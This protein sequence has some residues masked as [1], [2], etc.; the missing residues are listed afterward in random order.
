MKVAHLAE[1]PDAI[2]TLASWVYNQWGHWMPA[3]IIPETLAREFEKRT[4]PSC[5]PETFVAVEGHAPLGTA[6]LVIHDLAAR[7]DLSPWLAA[8]YVAPEFRNQGVGSALVQAVTDEAQALGVERL[9]LFTP[10]KMSFYGRLGWQ[11][12]ERT[13]H[14]GRDVTVMVYE[15]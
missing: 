11:A 12:L 10:D 8:V 3:D 2:P 14:Q 7:R 15:F 1:H 5:I 6:S 13:K 4:I 9:Y